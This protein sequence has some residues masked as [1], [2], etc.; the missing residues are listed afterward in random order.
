ML[1]D[2]MYRQQETAQTLTSAR[3]RTTS[4]AI[5]RLFATTRNAIA[6]VSELWPIV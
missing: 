4:G 6:A 5:A 3:Y 2:L 1:G